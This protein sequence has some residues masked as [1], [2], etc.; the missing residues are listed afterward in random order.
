MLLFGVFRRVLRLRWFSA[1]VLF[2][3][4]AATLATCACSL[5]GVAYFLFKP[6]L[7]DKITLLLVGLSAGVL[8]GDAFIHLMPESVE[9][10]GA[11]FF[12]VV[13]L[14]SF[15]FFFL[16]E[17]IVRWRHCH[18]PAHKHVHPF[19]YVNLF[20]DAVHNFIDGVIIAVSFLASTPLGIAT[21]IAVI[22]H[23]IPQELG[24]FGVLIYA[25]LSKRKALAFN[26]LVSL[27]AIAGALAGFYASSAVSGLQAF[28]LPVGAGSFVYLAC[29][30]LVPEMHKETQQGKALVAFAAFL[31]GIVI[32]YALKIAFEV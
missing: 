10:S 5:V 12:G 15:S 3:I 21:T 1:M 9:L 20:G 13:F 17:R 29:S 16:L 18:D 31:A 11:E 25:G 6:K 7:L 28:L 8:L 24:D 22:A 4:V 26:F 19:A 32:M 23:E 30:D 27:T 14:A 2:E